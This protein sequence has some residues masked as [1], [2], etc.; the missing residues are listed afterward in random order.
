MIFEYDSNNSGGGW[1]LSD[2]DWFALEKAGWKV[3]WRSEDKT[4]RWLDALATSATKEFKNIEDAIQEWQGITG[5]S[6]Y[7]SGC[8]CCGNPHYISEAY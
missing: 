5:K 6:Y 4:E 2:D 8:E 3:D 7:E 1:W